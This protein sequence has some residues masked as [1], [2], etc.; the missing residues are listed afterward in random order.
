MEFRPIPGQ[1]SRRKFLIA[2]ATASLGLSSIELAAKSFGENRRLLKPVHDQVVC[3]WSPR[4]PR[5][6]HQLI[7][8]LD[9]ERL[10]LVW[11]EYYS[12]QKNPQQRIGQ[13]GATDAV[14]CQI[15]SMVSRNRGRTWTN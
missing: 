1:L 10:L 14:S 6:D 15:S 4:H 8:P 5:H 11:T 3:P 2:S 7:F 9:D 12:R 13:T